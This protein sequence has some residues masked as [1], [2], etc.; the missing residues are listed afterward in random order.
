MR[1]PIDNKYIREELQ[2]ISDRLADAW[3]GPLREAPKMLEE[4]ALRIFNLEMDI[5]DGWRR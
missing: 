4:I 1:K 2:R 5:K 3:S